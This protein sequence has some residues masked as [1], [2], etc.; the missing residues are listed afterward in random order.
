MLRHK[1]VHAVSVCLSVCLSVVCLCSAID[2]TYFPGRC[3][4][5]LV[6][7]QKVGIL[8]V[9]HPHVL[10]SFDLTMP[11]SCLELDVEAFL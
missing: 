1:C 4:D 6:K 9:L 11:T 7:G 3:A 8:G 5:I 10:S 2:A